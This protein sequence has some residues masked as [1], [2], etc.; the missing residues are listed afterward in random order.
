MIGEGI[1]ATERKKKF[2]DLTPITPPLH[3]SSLSTT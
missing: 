2:Y 1:A 3:H